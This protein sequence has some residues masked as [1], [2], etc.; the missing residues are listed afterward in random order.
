M[1]HHLQKHLNHA[2]I[3]AFLALI[4]FFPVS[5]FSQSGDEPNVTLAWDAN[6]ED[7]LAGYMLYYKTGTGGAPY[8][9]TGL[10][11]GAS[12]ITIHLGELEDPDSPDYSVN[13]LEEG[14]V[15]YFALTAFDDD[16]LESDYSDEVSYSYEIP[17]V[18]TH[19]ISTSAGN[20]GYITP[21]GTIT[22]DEGSDRTFTIVPDAHYHVAR[23][24]VDGASVGQRGTYTFEDI[25][26]S[27]S[28]EAV[29]EIDTFTIIATA[30][31]NGG[32][33]PQGVISA[34][35]GTNGIF[36]VM[37]D[38]GYQIA[39]VI[40]DGSSVGPCGTYTFED[41]S[42]WHTIEAVFEESA[43][44][45]V[46][47][48]P[49]VEEDPMPDEGQGGTE[50]VSPAP[51]PESPAEEETPEEETPPQDE[52]PAGSTEQDTGDGGEASS[53]APETENPAEENDD[54]VTY[55]APETKTYTIDTYAGE[56]GY[57]TP[58]GTVTVE[59]GS[60]QTFTF[61]PDADYQIASVRVD[62]VSVEQ[63]SFIYTFKDIDDD[64]S[65]K[66]YFE[67]DTF[68]I[69]AT[70]GKN[71]GISPRGVISAAYGVR[72]TFT[73][74]PDD[75]YQI[76]DVIVDGT[77]VGPRNTFTFKNIDTWHTIEAV[78]EAAEE[79]P[80]DSKGQDAEDSEGETSDALDS[81]DE[82]EA[83]EEAATDDETTGSGEKE[84]L[85]GNQPP[86]S[87]VAATPT[88]EVAGNG[89]VEL[90]IGDFYDPDAG[91]YHAKTEWRVVRVSDEVTVLS[92]T[93]GS[94][95]EGITVPGIM[96]D[97][98]SAYRWQ[99]RVF[100]NH[101]TPSEWSEAASFSTGFYGE[102]ANGDGVPDAQEVDIFVD[103]NSDGIPDAEQEVMK[104]FVAPSSG[105]PMGLSIENS[106]TVTAILYAEGV[107]A[108]GPELWKNIE[109]ASMRLPH[110]L[111][112]FKLA[113][114]NPGDAA[115][116]TIH[117]S[118]AAPAGAR[119]MK[120]DTLQGIWL[121]YTGYAQ[122]SDDR[123]AVELEFV[124]GGFGDEDG[125]A[126]GIIVDPA[127]LELSMEM[128]TL[129]TVDSL[130]TGSLDGGSSDIGEVAGGGDSEGE[131]G[132]GGC[133]ISG[134][135]DGQ[136]ARLPM[137]SYIF[138]L[139]GVVVSVCFRKIAK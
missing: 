107:A 48:D 118:E 5:A 67:I 74:T 59:E 55:T 14:S 129:D 133:F 125:V 41:I 103:L 138:I 36:T 61:V 51:E 18:A 126:N 105:M 72:G 80:A 137:S 87:P 11:E 99:A 68:T 35:Y 78:F 63:V 79:Q 6:S 39:D 119:W 83:G 124:D 116:V 21:D 84:D 13:G 82:D 85:D 1:T 32:I 121:D 45:I 25:D 28:I 47:D 44:I 114:E 33:S 4:I 3:I 127:G 19:T 12:P 54:G 123:M 101:G 43:G 98:N 8:D 71:G 27:H 24:L 94:S 38:D 112:N 86:A 10:I 65:I 62:G 106:N 69:T 29:F 102:D 17:E 120:F 108:D 81:D 31:E 90:S 7:N 104:S 135:M 134:S 9:G 88:I 115:T 132:G 110:G 96:L 89:P 42:I 66:A 26:A 77:S 70:A 131:G 37:P 53:P 58:N 64:H 92:F 139:L 52:Q 97:V 23:V 130:D 100:D 111:I 128:E 136:T 46:V 60:D 93:G 40:V 75:G 57:I 20:H 95:P 15:Y 76:A 34:A 109:N 113:V 30:G 16:G 73:I 49:P 117:F 56:H 50:A 91:D 122:F 22:V 2:A